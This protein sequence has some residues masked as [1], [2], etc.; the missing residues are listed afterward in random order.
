MTVTVFPQVK[1][2]TKSDPKWWLKT[3]SSYQ[4][5]TAQVFLKVFRTCIQLDTLF[6]S[7]WPNSLRTLTNLWLSHDKAGLTFFTLHTL[8][9]MCKSDSAQLHSQSEPHPGHSHNTAWA[10]LDYC[11]LA[12]RV[13]AFNC[14]KLECSE[15]T[16]HIALPT[17]EV[18]PD[19][20]LIW[21]CRLATGL[22]LSREHTV[23][24]H[25][26]HVNS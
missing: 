5:W 10:I 23:T 18:W 8:W 25:N 3:H 13:Q 14:A 24:G 17:V 26:A 4:V 15:K 2:C 19:T 6:S 16:E 11:W 7:F 12:T 1:R 20:L 21:T 22:N 9:S